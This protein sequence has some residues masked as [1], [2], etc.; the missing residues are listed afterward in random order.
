L[1]F[2]THERYEPA[3]AFGPRAPRPYP[4]DLELSVLK[5]Y[6]DSGLPATASLPLPGGGPCSIEPLLGGLAALVRYPAVSQGPVVAPHS[7]EAA[8][9]RARRLTVARP[10]A[11]S[12]DSLFSELRGEPAA[13]CAREAA[14]CILDLGALI[15]WVQAECPHALTQAIAADAGR[16]AN[17]VLSD[18]GMVR[19]I[20]S[21]RLLS[22][23]FSPRQCDPE[24]LGVQLSSSM[25][26]M[27]GAPKAAQPALVSFMNIQ[28]ASPDAAAA[29]RDM[30][31]TP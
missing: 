31:S 22:V 5:P 25:M 7:D 4:P 3:L 24:L 9:L 20:P 14:V 13:R 12:A 27:F 2:L 11:L 28:L 23:N 29:L 6:L 18:T 21:R 19:L 10:P 26:R 8:E 17:L 15:A 1:Y 30:L 16:F